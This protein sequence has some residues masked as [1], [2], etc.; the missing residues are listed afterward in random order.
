[1]MNV[2]IVLIN[3]ILTMKENVKNVPWQDVKDVIKLNAANVLIIAKYVLK[4]GV[5]LNAGTATIGQEQIVQDARKQIAYT[6]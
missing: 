5:V 3:I 1:M 2:L 4:T 6:L